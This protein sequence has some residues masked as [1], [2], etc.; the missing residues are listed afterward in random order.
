MARSKRRRGSAAHAKSA[1]AE[2]S[3]GAAWG[4]PALIV[5]VAVFA[6]ANSL[7][8]PFVYDDYVAIVQNQ[9]IQDLSSAKVLA[10][11]ANTPL[12]GRPLVNLSFAVNY[13]LGG[14]NPVGYRVVNL[15]LHIAC[16][17]LVYALVRRFLP[18]LA[19]AIALIWTVHPLNS[20]VVNYITQRTES[21]MAACFLLTLYA[22]T[23]E[24]RWRSRW[25][26]AAV[27]TCV[28]GIFCKEPIAVAPLAV[29]LYDSALVFGSVGAAV[30]ARWRF[31]TALASTWVL[32]G[33]MVATHGQS[34]AA[35][36]SSAGVSVWTYLLNQS[37][38]ITRY[39]R[40]AV[41][42]Q[43]LV[44]NY[45][46]P[47]ALTVADVWPY[48]LFV[49]IV[50]AITIVALIRRP[51]VGALAA[52]VFLTLGP[53]S[54]LIP[55]G[56]EVGA[57]RRMYLALIGI[58]ALVV[59]GARWVWQRVGRAVTARW[60]TVVPAATGVVVVAAGILATAI[61][62]LEYRSPLAMSQT[63]L[64]RWPSA[65]AHNAVGTELAAAGR[66]QEALPHLRQAVAEYPVA[67]YFLG[68]LLIRTGQ[69]A[70][71]VG[72]LQKFIQDEPALPQRNVRIMLAQAYLATGQPV[73]AIEQFKVVIAQ[74]PDDAA[75]HAIVADLLAEQQ[76]FGDAIPYYQA[77][78]KANPGN[79]NAWTGLG[80]AFVATGKPADAATAFRSAV[81]I[82][83]KNS[84][85]RQNLARALLAS[86]AIADAL[87]EAQQAVTHGPTDPVSFDVLGQA[88]AKSGRIADARITFQRA[89]QLDPT[90]Q[91]AIAALRALR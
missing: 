56:T 19:L 38:M 30:R 70:E 79:V 76:A 45:G 52:W 86:G 29:L 20:E 8:N 28:A 41:W 11:E 36:F 9:T 91:P 68:E 83:P 71:A 24:G 60:L 42:P 27:L 57:E 69:P 54:S 74:K 1:D 85:L 3:R 18:A 17:L 77:F 7:R 84:R 67:R 80:V 50:I 49:G 59:L 25:Q 35:G 63:M 26:V 90:Y 43:G 64:A 10:P 13:A 61:R 66:L 81:D 40:L 62:N 23:A 2:H 65:V 44:V 34:F 53:T 87:T 31:Y 78:L 14:R 15:G 73:A 21:M 33:V 48:L 82:D 22:A 4:A 39:L 58:I 16:G 47:R 72:V 55:I 51:R 89:L 88:L 46:W 75:P 5:L 6:Y 32:M 12:A 37:V